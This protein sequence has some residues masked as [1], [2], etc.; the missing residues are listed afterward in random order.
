MAKKSITPAERIEQRIALIR[1]E[2]VIL[3]ANVAALYGVDTHTVVPAVKR[4][5]QR[6]PG[7]F[8]FQLPPEEYQACLES[9]F[10]ISKGR[11]AS[12]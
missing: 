4:N 10:V 2:R 8:M 6:F 3:D 5:R 12:G 1:G 11:A 7:D 9:R